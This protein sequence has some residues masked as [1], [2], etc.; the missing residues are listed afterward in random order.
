MI[1]RALLVGCNY[2]NKK[3]ELKGCVND[4]ERMRIL[5]EK[6]FGFGKD[7]IIQLVDTD[8]RG[9]QPTGANI[10]ACLVR[11]AST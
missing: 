6:R 9:A 2:P 10:R 5:L 3:C 11:T 8:P 7:Q 1:K 4:V